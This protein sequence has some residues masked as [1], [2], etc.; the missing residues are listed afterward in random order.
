MNSA[1]TFF[2]ETAL[3]LLV[4]IAVDLCAIM[5]VP[6]IAVSLDQAYLLQL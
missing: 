6:A 4:L 1:L 2:R 5:I 3:L